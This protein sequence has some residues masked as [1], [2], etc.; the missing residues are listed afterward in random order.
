MVSQRFSIYPYLCLGSLLTNVKY[1]LVHL[2]NV[3]FQTQVCTRYNLNCVA[4]PKNAL[5]V[6]EASFYFFLVPIEDESQAHRT[7]SMICRDHCTDLRMNLS[8]DD[9]GQVAW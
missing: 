4:D 9:P 7:K 5:Y 3:T 6:L 2:N 1:F 8:C